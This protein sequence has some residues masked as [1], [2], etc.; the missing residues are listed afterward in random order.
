M[1]LYYNTNEYFGEPGPFEAESK[2]ALA[3]EMT[4]SFE[5]WAIEYLDDQGNEWSDDEVLT[6]VD[7]LKREFVADL[8]PAAA[9]GQSDCAWGDASAVCWTAHNRA[10]V[11]R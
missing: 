11:K 8:I 1:P 10:G 6:V 3:D 7:K 5:I 9:V 2:E 4:K